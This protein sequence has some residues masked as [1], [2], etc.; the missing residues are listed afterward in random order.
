MGRKFFVK[1]NGKKA[2]ADSLKKIKKLLTSEDIYDIISS[3]KGSR[4]VVKDVTSPSGRSKD[5]APFN[6]GLFKTFA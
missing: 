4:R 2:K 6:F 5:S 1:R 3:L